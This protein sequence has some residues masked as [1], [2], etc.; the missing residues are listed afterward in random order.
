MTAFVVINL[1]IAVICDA[2]QILRTAEEALIEEK[3]YGRE[4]KEDEPDE[5]GD[6]D[7]DAAVDGE[8]GTNDRLRQRID[9]MQK[10]LDEM[11]MAQETM[12]RTIQYLSI[13]M[14]AERRTDDLFSGE[15]S[16]QESIREDDSVKESLEEAV[17][18][19]DER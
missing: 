17:N 7:D 5:A 6:G 9:E 16:V 8:E 12:A 10:M 15:M 14:Y 13:A 19:D 11:I 2:L 18:M 1:M 4:P 3:L